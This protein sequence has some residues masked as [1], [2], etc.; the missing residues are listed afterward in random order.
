MINRDK[1]VQAPWNHSP[2]K[3]MYSFGRANR[4]LKPRIPYCLNQYK[5]PTTFDSK[6]CTFGAGKRFRKPPDL[7]PS[8]ADYCAILP[9]SSKKRLSCTFGV[10]REAF[11]RVYCPHHPYPDP[12]IPGPGTYTVLHNRNIIK[13][14]RSCSTSTRNS[15]F[16]VDIGLPGPGQYEIFT[17]FTGTGRQFISKYKSTMAP[18]FN[19]QKADR[20]DGIRKDSPGPCKY[21]P[22]QKFQETGSQQFSKFKRDTMHLN[23]TA[24]ENPGPGEYQAAAEFGMTPLIIPKSASAF[25][26]SQKHQ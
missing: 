16:G 20:F 22:V 14:I 4:F 17:T 1:T 10:N 8:P 19:S 2:S 13:S 18:Y 26:R 9:L 23:K 15:I 5:L 21:T 11:A 25:R 3:Q 6:A 7:T 24:L 12:S